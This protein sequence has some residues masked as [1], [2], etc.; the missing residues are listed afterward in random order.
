MITPKSVHLITNSVAAAIFVSA[1]VASPLAIPY[2]MRKIT[3]ITEVPIIDGINL[4]GLI[5]IPQTV[6]A[7]TSAREA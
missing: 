7:T 2:E 4:L 6:K 5:M 3:S 1:P